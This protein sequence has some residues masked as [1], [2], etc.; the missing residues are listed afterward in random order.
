MKPVKEE[1]RDK[2][3]V[4]LYIT[5]STSP[6]EEWKEM[7]KTIPGEHYYL[8]PEQFE[9]LGRLYQSGGGIP[10]YAIYNSKGELVHN[11]IGFAIV[12]PLKA[13]LMKALE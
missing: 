12:D 13:G 9:A 6:Y 1:L 11:S 3:I 2:N 5:S 10:V 4:Y 8:L 7:I